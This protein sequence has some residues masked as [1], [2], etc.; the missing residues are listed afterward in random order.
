MK[1]VYFVEG[2]ELHNTVV[3][4]DLNMAERWVTIRVLD[5]S[6]SEKTH[7]SKRPVAERMQLVVSMA[8]VGSRC[9][10]MRSHD[11]LPF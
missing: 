8:A 7:I 5:S 10:L 3:F 2:Q 6:G 11:P 9:Y 4:I 1:H